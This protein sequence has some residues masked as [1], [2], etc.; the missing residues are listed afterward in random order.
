MTSTTA[1]TVNM[2]S[3]RI[4]ARLD[5]RRL[6]DSSTVDNGGANASADNNELIRRSVILSHLPLDT[7]SL[8][9]EHSMDI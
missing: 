2:T 3:A 5:V 9:Y 1:E 7:L 6:A 8:R 4:R